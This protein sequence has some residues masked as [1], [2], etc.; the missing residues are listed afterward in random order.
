MKSRFFYGVFV[1]FILGCLF[2]FGVMNVNAQTLK[3]NEYEATYTNYYDEGGLYAYNGRT[4]VYTDY[5]W[6]NRRSSEYNYVS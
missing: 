3:A 5:D 6:N 2:F 4:G 1:G